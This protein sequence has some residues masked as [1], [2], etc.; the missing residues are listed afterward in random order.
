MEDDDE[1]Q[2][3]AIAFLDGPG[4]GALHEFVFESDI[5]WGTIFHNFYPR[6]P[7]TTRALTTRNNNRIDVLL[8]WHLPFVPAALR[9]LIANY[10]HYHY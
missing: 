3:I 9:T 8:W 10:I 2:P 6:H 1:E 4:D 5:F 7:H